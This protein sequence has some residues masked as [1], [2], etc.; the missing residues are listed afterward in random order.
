MF[1]VHDRLMSFL[2]WVTIIH[3]S[4]VI[5]V[6][7]FYWNLATVVVRLGQGK[8]LRT[9]NDLTEERSHKDVGNNCREC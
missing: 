3:V 4:N 1:S 6:S 9:T 5:Y 2:H 7:H 8:G